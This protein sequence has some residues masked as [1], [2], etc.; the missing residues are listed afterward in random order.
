VGKSVLEIGKGKENKVRQMLIAASGVNTKNIALMKRLLDS[1]DHQYEKIL[2]MDK[3]QLMSFFEKF[4]DEF[5][6]SKDRK[7]T[8][9]IK[10]RKK[11]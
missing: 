8:L 4:V 5:I 9:K 1:K 10:R 3:D 6:A 2:L 11:K 7:E